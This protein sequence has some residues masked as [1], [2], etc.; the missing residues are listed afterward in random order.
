MGGGGGG[1]IKFGGAQTEKD[2]QVLF[3][4]FGL[5]DFA[6]LFRTAFALKWFFFALDSLFLRDLIC[7][8]S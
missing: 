2:L 5:I 8:H 3:K 4:L 6:L 7:S 1:C